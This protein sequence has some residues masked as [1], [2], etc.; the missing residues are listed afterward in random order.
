MPAACELWWLVNGYA[1]KLSE[2][3]YGTCSSIG[4]IVQLVLIAL[5]DSFHTT[6]TSILCSLWFL[7]V[8]L[9]WDG[10]NI[11]FLSTR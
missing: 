8:I 11:S 7:D 1:N 3:T 10:Y 4:D 9:D 6:T 5:I 2:R